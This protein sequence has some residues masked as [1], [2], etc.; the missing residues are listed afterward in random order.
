MTYAFI[1]YLYFT[2]YDIHT[3]LVR[4]NEWYMVYDT[5][6]AW[7]TAAPFAVIFMLLYM[8]GI[9]ASFAYLLWKKTKQGT[10]DTYHIIDMMKVVQLISMYQDVHVS[11]GARVLCNGV[12][13]C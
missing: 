3:L 11:D 2:L 7:V 5:I 8:F 4:C 1:S 12:V 6:G 13:A 9:P 10:V